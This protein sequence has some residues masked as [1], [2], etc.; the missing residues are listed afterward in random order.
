MPKLKTKDKQSILKDIIKIYEKKGYDFKSE[1]DKHKDPVRVNYSFSRRGFTPDLHGEH[2]DGSKIIFEIEA[3]VTKEI[4][5]ELLQK[6]IL[7]SAYAN[8]FHGKFFIVIPDTK[9]REKVEK[10]VESKKIKAEVVAPEE[11]G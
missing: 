3:K 6:W 2:K 4:F 8:Q 5:P 9:T 11:I 1:L 10:M 7:F